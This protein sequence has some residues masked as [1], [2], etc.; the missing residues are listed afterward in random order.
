MAFPVI[1]LH[2]MNNYG[3]ILISIHPDSRHCR[4]IYP[5]NGHNVMITEMRRIDVRHV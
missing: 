4:T 5:R 1:L 3:Q 2:A